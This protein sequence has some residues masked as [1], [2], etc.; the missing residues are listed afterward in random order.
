VLLYCLWFFDLGNRQP[1][2]KTAAL[3]RQKAIEMYIPPRL[4]PGVIDCVRD[5]PQGQLGAGHG[6]VVV[7]S[8]PQGIVQL[9]A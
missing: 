5:N 8:A 3:T 9:S 2:I 7:A 1:K 4:T 6:Q